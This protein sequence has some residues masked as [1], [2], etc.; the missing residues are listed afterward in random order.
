[1]KKVT[2]GTYVPTAASQVH[3]G[4]LGAAKVRSMDAADGGR[5]GC[6][7]GLGRAYGERYGTIG[8]GAARPRRS[9][10]AGRPA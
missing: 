8:D 9:T 2:G 6:G 10:W 7:L 5:R 4:G 1:M 3:P